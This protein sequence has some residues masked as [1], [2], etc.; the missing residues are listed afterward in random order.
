MM[1]LNQSCGEKQ[2][3]NILHLLIAVFMPFFFQ[4]QAA[5][6]CEAWCFYLLWHG[7]LFFIAAIF[8]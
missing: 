4:A 8:L 5:R 3:K 1:N 7:Q 6:E 2:C